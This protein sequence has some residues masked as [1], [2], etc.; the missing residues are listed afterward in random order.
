MS[1]I[2]AAVKKATEYL[3]AL[4]EPAVMTKAEAV[5]YLEEIVDHCRTSIEALK[6]EMEGD[7]DD[8]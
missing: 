7:D 5:S 1:K 2:N 4:C 3:D 8:D 6:E